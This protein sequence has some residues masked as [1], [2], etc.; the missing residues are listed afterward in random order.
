M[1]KREKNVKKNSIDLRQKG[2]QTMTL[3]LHLDLEWVAVQEKVV[4]EEALWIAAPQ[5]Q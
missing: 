2:K 5:S 4:E 3:K 1:R